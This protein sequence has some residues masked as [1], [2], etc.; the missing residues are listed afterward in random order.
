MFTIFFRTIILYLLIILGIRLMGKRQVG[1]LEPS[2]LVLSF[3]IADLASVPMQDLGFPLHTG[4]I[5][6]LTLISISSIFSV[7]AMKN[8][9]FRNLL[10]GKPS[11]II[12][13]GT[14]DQKEMRR[15]RLT[16]DELLEELRCNGHT[17]LTT[18][19]YA[20]LESNGMLSILLFPQY[21]PATVEDLTKATTTQIS[22][23]KIGLPRVL[24]SDGVLLEENLAHSGFDRHWL[25]QKLKE[26]QCHTI[27]DAF[28]FLVNQDG[29]Y[30]FTKKW[31]ESQMKGGNSL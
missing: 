16:M 19:Q 18:I 25:E 23:Q 12:R 15:N 22:L 14:I 11:I 29:T 2:E 26:K 3:L 24:I 4:L 5:P 7:V 27:E 30:Y 10:C 21:Q 1:E 6:I 8:L 17:D 9:F 20:V 13:N 28:L 31:E